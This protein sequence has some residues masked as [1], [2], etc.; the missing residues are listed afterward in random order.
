MTKKRHKSLL[1]YR[2]S[3]FGDIAM[4]IPVLRSFYQIYPDQKI[5]FVSRA[6]VKPLF[7][8]FPN[9]ILS[10]M[11]TREVPPEVVS[12]CDVV[13]MLLPAAMVKV[14]VELSR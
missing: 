10:P 4:I 12:F 9:L 6:F 8:E 5:I 7:E 14:P 13:A 2:F 3:S 1:V 11:L